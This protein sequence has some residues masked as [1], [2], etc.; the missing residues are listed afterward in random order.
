M[1]CVYVYMCVR[2]C[3]DIKGKLLLAAYIQTFDD[4]LIFIASTIKGFGPAAWA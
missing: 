4:L 1:T 3:A 2:K